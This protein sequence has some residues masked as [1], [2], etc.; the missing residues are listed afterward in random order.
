MGRPKSIIRTTKLNTSLPEDLRQQLDDHLY[1]P[2]SQ[3]I[4]PGSY[5]KF[6]ISRI[7]EYFSWSRVDLSLFG[8]PDGYFFVAPKEMAEKI[9]QRLKGDSN[10]NSQ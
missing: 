3:M 9:V 7:R 2:W 5:Q 1:E 10:V 6:I 8:L 4:P